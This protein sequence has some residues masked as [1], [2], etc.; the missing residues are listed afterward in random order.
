[1]S[2]V[3]AGHAVVRAGLEDYRQMLVLRMHLPDWSAALI[4][5]VSVGLALVVLTAMLLP[6]G[7]RPGRWA[8]EL[9]ADPA[10]GQAR[11]G[12]DVMLLVS[13]LAIVGLALAVYLTRP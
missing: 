12:L 6:S 3:V 9:D 2:G 11:P 8:D 13:T 10:P 7:R 4:V 5:S 1:M